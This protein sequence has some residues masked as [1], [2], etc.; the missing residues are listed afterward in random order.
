[1]SV[2]VTELGP[3]KDL[4]EGDV[5]VEVEWTTIQLQGRAG[6]HQARSGVRPLADGSG[7]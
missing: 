1:M 5:V 2:N 3:Q 4:N 6:D 7:D